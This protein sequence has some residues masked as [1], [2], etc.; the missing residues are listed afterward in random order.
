VKDHL[1]T[2]QQ[3]LF[4]KNT[5]EIQESLR[6]IFKRDIQIEITTGSTPNLLYGRHLVITIK[7]T[8]T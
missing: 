3:K 8:N 5:K 2:V 1:E 7:D 4:E 6:K